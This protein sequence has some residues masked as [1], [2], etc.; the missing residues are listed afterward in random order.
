MYV[1]IIIIM[2]I[3]MSTIVDIHNNISYMSMLS[4]NSIL[5]IFIFLKFCS[6]IKKSQKIVIDKFIKLKII[7]NIYLSEYENNIYLLNSCEYVQYLIRHASKIIDL[8]HYKKIETITI[9]IEITNKNEFKEIILDD[10]F[11]IHYK[12]NGYGIANLMIECINNIL[13]IQFIVGGNTINTYISSQHPPKYIFNILKNNFFP[14]LTYHECKIRFHSISNFSITFDIV[15]NINNYLPNNNIY[16][17]GKNK[18][19][20]SINVM[21]IIKHN[22]IP[23]KKECIAEKI[24]IISSV[25]IKNVLL[26][27]EINNNIHKI[28]FIKKNNYWILNFNNIYI[29]LHD[30]YYC[31]KYNKNINL[32]IIY[33]SECVNHIIDL[34]ITCYM[35][36]YIQYYPSINALP[37]FSFKDYLNHY[38]ISNTSLCASNIMDT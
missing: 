19:F 9:N 22:E 11:D 14:I 30:R 33:D 24:K 32:K 29:A 18:I 20:D 3:N 31:C 23:I 15:K 25:N 5:N 1:Y 6:I 36:I 7:N 16:I 37:V 10:Y 13:F 4:Q 27:Y 8:K 2:N 21:P 26:T 34:H 38:E 35:P 17:N 12:L 28:S